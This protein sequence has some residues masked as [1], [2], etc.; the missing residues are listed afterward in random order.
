M[1]H[2]AKCKEGSQPRETMEQHLLTFLNTKADRFAPFV[3]RVGTRVFENLLIEQRKRLNANEI[4]TA[5]NSTTVRVTLSPEGKLKDIEIVE[6]SGSQSMDGTLLEAL[7]AAAF[8]ANP[9]R[10]ASREDG[11]YEFIFRAQVLAQ[12]GS[13]SSGPRLQRVESRLQVGLN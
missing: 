10:E 8:D 7:R 6:R 2:D 11:T 4:L 3:R 1:K 13:G 5:R 9:P 12:V